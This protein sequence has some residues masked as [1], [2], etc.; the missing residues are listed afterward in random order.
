MSGPTF[1]AAF[2]KV[3][4]LTGGLHILLLESRNTG[5]RQVFHSLSESG[6]S[7]ATASTDHRQAEKRLA[8]S[9]FFEYCRCSGLISHAYAFCLLIHKMETL[10]TVSLWIPFHHTGDVPYNSLMR[11]HS[12]IQ[13]LSASSQ[14]LLSTARSETASERWRGRICSS[15]SRSAIVLATFRIRL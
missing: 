9:R 11:K 6:M 4:W 13:F 8:G 14:Y 10:W 12:Y 1:A 3:P 15:S 7:R 2:E 5:L